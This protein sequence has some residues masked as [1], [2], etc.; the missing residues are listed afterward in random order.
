MSFK[1]L[2]DEVL[3][4]TNVYKISEILSE[5]NLTAKRPGGGT[6]PM[7]WDEI[8]GTRATKDYNKDELI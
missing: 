6:S 8:V 7:K 1:F 3:P 2:K 4:N 5:K